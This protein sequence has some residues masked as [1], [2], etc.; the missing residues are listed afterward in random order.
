MQISYT[1]STQGSKF[2]ANKLNETMIYR[3][4]TH[5]CHRGK[6][7]QTIGQVYSCGMEKQKQLH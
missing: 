4:Q 3:T 5:P 7:G 6:K 1:L 2:Q